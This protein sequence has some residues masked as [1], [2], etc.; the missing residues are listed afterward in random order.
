MRTAR[1]FLVFPLPNTYAEDYTIWSL[2]EGLLR[3]S[4]KDV[5]QEI[6]HSHQ[7][8]IGTKHRSCGLPNCHTEN[9]RITPNR[10]SYH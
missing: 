10:L 5:S 2:P 1:V 6:S 7:M 3:D 8:V 4:V 9:S